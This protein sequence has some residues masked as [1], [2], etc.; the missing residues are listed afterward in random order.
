VD[1]MKERIRRELERVEP[2]PGG[3][4][5]TLR[6]VGRRERSRRVGAGA[7][8]LLLMA[9][10]GVGLW[11]SLA[12]GRRQPVGPPTPRAVSGGPRLFL[13]GD[14]ELWVVDVDEGSVRHLQLPE[15]SAGDPPYR[16]VRRGEKLVLWG[17]HATYV[18]DPAKVGKPRVLAEGTLIFIPSAMPNRVWLGIGRP[19]E[20][21]AVREVAVDGRVTVRD[22]KPPGGRW[23]VAATETTLAFQ[24]PDGRLEVWDPSTGDV[25]R[26]LPGEFPIATYGDHLAWC[27]DL[28]LTLHVTNV[29][30]GD[31]VEVSP[32]SGTYAFEPY[33]GAFSPDGRVIAVTVHADAS[34]TTRELQLAL[35]DA[36]AGTTTLVQGTAVEGDVFVDWSPSGESVFIS[37]GVAKR[38]IIE[39]Q[40]GA[41][42]TRRLP[43]QVGA[44]YGMA[45]A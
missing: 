13:A 3:L 14:G 18:L 44:F 6:R 32:P 27:A 35:V 40:V 11:L 41:D 9:G 28:C 4:E 15:L 38:S 31:E 39:Y 21:S 19:E 7:V 36:G 1:D 43:V 10:L 45:A 42:S 23:P 30:T 29:V 25:V 17:S 37:S 26:R 8:G 16:I 12:P 20:L 33:I 22:T 5:K 2:S 34:L 24:T